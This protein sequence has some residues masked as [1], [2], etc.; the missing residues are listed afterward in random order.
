MSTKF[1]IRACAFRIRAPRGGRALESSKIAN[2]ELQRSSKIEKF[3]KLRSAN[4]NP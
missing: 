4:E 1:S 3:M 2:E